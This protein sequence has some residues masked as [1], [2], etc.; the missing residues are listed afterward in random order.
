MTILTCL[1]IFSTILSIEARA[2]QTRI[3]SDG[4][5]FAGQKNSGN[6]LDGEE[7]AYISRYAMNGGQQGSGEARVHTIFPGIRRTIDPG[8]QEALD[9]PIQADD[10]GSDEGKTIH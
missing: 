9:Q 1:V 2:E 7:P 3:Y 8:R 6:N 5:I 4:Q 10:R